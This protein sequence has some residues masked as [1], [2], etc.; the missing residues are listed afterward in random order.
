MRRLIYSDQARDELLE[1]RRYIAA[2]SGSNEVALQFA[3]RLREQ[4]RRLAELPGQ[5]GRAR[6]DLGKT[7]R[8]FPY[9]NYVILFRYEASSVEIVSIVEGHR[10]IEALFESR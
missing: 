3:G 2:R 7:L 6:P 4:C 1:I 8:S 9:G 10:D 5:L